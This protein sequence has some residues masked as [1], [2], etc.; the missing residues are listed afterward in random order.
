VCGII[1]AGIALLVAATPTFAQSAHGLLH[2]LP[3]LRNDAIV[4]G[5]LLGVLAFVFGT[6]TSSSPGWKKFYTFVPPIFVCYFLPSIFTSTRIISPEHSNLYPVA[7]DY[8]L[9]TSL[10][11]LTLSIDFKAVLRLGPKALT[12]FLVGT[13][14]IIIGGPL[15]LAIVGAFRPEW[16]GGEG[17]ESVWRGLTTVAGSW[18]GGGANQAAMKEI[19]EVGDIFSPMVAVDIIV[20]NIWCACLL[21]IA[22]KSEQIDARLGADVSAIEDLKRRVADY[23]AQV[24][25]VPRTADTMIVLA[26]G[27]GATAV[28]HL[29]AEVL[30]PTFAG[31]KWAEQLNLHSKFFWIVVT[32]TTLGLALSFTRA[33]ALEGVGASR[34]GTVCLFILVVTIGMK[35]DVRAVAAHPQLFLI[36]GIWM[37]FHAVVMIV[38]CRLIRAPV[39][40]MAVGSQANVGGAAS[41]PIVASA[42]HPSLAT[43]GVLLAVLGYALGTF[44]AYLCGRLMEMVAP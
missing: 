7:R 19:F 30:S 20:A 31:A 41:A 3:L 28:S 13:A 1:V 12:L 24:S 22:G 11:L 10:V 18:I 38:T 33:R 17:S 39:F 23:Q 36:G 4:L 40:F 9:P 16:V 29:V 43:V 25:R 14:S 5:I 27:F 8:L 15:A 6:S 26:V 34:L 2:S 32:A 35:M 37:L 42:F 21:I 44:G